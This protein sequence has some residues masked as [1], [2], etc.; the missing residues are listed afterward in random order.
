MPQR[1]GGLEMVLLA[2]VHSFL[3]SLLVSILNSLVF[4]KNTIG[5][6]YDFNML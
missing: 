2:I 4:L 3:L 6:E 1:S 5:V